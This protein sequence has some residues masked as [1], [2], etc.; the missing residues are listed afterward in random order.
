MPRQ[1]QTAFWFA[2]EL[3]G[4]EMLRSDQLDPAYPRHMHTTFTIGV[5]DMGV[6]VNQSRGET[7]YI[8]Q[9]SV[10]VFNPGDVHSGHASHDLLISHRT[11]YPSEAALTRLAHDIG[12][13][14]A[15]YF[16]SSSLYAP[17]SAERLR[18]LHRLLER[19]ESLLERE[20]AV[21]EVF[22]TLLTQHTPLLVSSRPEANE[23]RAVQEVRDYLEAHLAEN[24]SLD[25][26]ADLV[27]LNRAYL[28]RVFRRSVGIPP[29]TYLIQI[30]VEHAKSLLRTGA[31]PAQVALEVGFGDQ[32]HLNL[33]F[34]RVMNLTPGRYARSHYLPRQVEG[35]PSR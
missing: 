26:L 3:G 32:S 35:K 25:A 5:V 16:K 20:S 27:G 18:A 24:V 10:Y 7:S 9:N 28:I 33:H 23:P 15:P 29:Y 11:F 4:M 22:G 1:G 30:R 34:K 21:V 6:V 14:G 19:S 8:P 17:R 2:R 13:R 12:L 31:D